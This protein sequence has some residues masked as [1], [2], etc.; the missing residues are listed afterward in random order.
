[1]RAG[2][3]PD[4]TFF[5]TNERKYLLG[6]MAFFVLYLWVIM[7]GVVVRCTRRVEEFNYNIVFLDCFPTI[8]NRT[9]S[10]RFVVFFICSK[11]RWGSSMYYSGIGDNWSNL[12]PFFQ[13]SNCNCKYFQTSWNLFIKYF[14][15]RWELMGESGMYL[16]Q[17]RHFHVSIFTVKVLKLFEKNLN[18]KKWSI[19]WRFIR[20]FE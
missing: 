15:Q 17:C 3:P 1:M 2:I 5:V 20:I 7:L 9:L 18:Y 19:I 16:E 13:A 11:F 14:Q 8:G 12:L 10:V 6:V 4:R